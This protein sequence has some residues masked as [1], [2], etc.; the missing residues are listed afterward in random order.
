V[1]DFKELIVWQK[2]HTLALEIYRVTKTFPKDELYGLVSQMR[3]CA[4]S[5]PSNIAEGCGRRSGDTELNRF[6]EIALG[7]ATELEY[8]CFL[9]KDLGFVDEE[10]HLQ[11]EQQTKQIQKMIVAFQRTLQSQQAKSKHTTGSR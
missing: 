10:T 2:A 9:A 8:Q 11:L 4:T 1:K 7:S 5:V 3:R 6:L